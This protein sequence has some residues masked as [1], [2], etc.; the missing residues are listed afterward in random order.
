MRA[1]PDALRELLAVFVAVTAATVLVSWIGRRSP[2]GDYV[3][4]VVGALFLWTALRLAQREPDGLARYGL[5]LGGLLEPSEPPPSGLFA[6]AKDLLAALARA[7]P[8]ALRE[9]GV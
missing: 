8:E 4:V 6:G 2:L 7:T 3:H 5:Q 1:R 9:L